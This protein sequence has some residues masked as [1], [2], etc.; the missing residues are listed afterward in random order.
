MWYTP[1]EHR[2]INLSSGRNALLHGFERCLEQGKNIVTLSPRACL[3]HRTSILSRRSPPGKRQHIPRHL[4]HRPLESSLG[5]ASTSVSQ[6]VFPV[7]L[8]R[9]WAMRSEPDAIKSRPPAVM[10]GPFL[11]RSERPVSLMAF[12]AKPTSQ[13]R[14]CEA[15][16]LPYHTK[17]GLTLCRANIRSGTCSPALPDKLCSSVLS[18][19]ASS[20]RP[21]MD[22]VPP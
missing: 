9:A 15:P 13:N 5:F 21:L 18:G 11:I 10:T 22:P 2:T 14:R 7:S 1:F 12:A 20:G 3:A 19:A 16:V 17:P 8:S 4:P 6:S